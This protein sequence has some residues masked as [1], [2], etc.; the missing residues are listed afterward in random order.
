M[1]FTSGQLVGTSFL[2]RLEI[3]N[4]LAAHGYNKIC[5]TGKQHFQTETRK[6][7]LKDK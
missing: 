7:K 5:I 1:T 2:P 6:R 3:V 4:E